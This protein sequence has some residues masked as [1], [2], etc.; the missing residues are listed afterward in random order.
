MLNVLGRT[1]S[2]SGT[3]LFS[4]PGGSLVAR[5]GGSQRVPWGIS[6]A[7][8][9]T[10]SAPG[11]VSW[12]AKWQSRDHGKN[13]ISLMLEKKFSYL[14]EEGPLDMIFE[15]KNVLHVPI[16]TQELLI[17]RKSKGRDK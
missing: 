17:S 13:W 14:G 10:G 1:C 9:C 7:A 16:Q 2:F 12:A 5:R 4:P 3:Q 11:R 15:L 8:G 6:R